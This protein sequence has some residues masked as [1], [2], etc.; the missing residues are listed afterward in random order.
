VFVCSALEAFHIDE[1]DA[2]EGE[3]Q[4]NSEWHIEYRRLTTLELLEWDYI[5]RRRDALE[6]K[7]DEVDRLRRSATALRERVKQLIEIMDEDHGKAIRVFTITTV[8]FLP[9]YV[10]GHCT[11]P[12][13]RYRV[14]AE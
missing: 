10:S 14:A 13:H 3:K 2:R 4:N 12:S 5:L 6:A 8:L 9:M 11:H 1:D 7:S